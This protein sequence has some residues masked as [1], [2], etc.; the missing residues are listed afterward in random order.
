MTVESKLRSLLVQ[1]DTI[2]NPFRSSTKQQ[3]FQCLIRPLTKPLAKQ[4]DHSGSHHS[5]ICVG[6]KQV[7]DDKDI[8]V[9]DVSPGIENFAE[10]IK[11]LIPP[12]QDPEREIMH[13]IKLQVKKP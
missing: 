2:L 12:C 7:H 10:R 5:D 9:I 3:E 8:G 11:A 4:Q 6:I 1:L 13:S